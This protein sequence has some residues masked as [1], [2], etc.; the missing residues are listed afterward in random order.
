MVRVLQA[1]E[2]V[3]EVKLD[4]LDKGRASQLG[5]RHGAR[6]VG[7]KQF[8]YKEFKLRMFQAHTFILGIPFQ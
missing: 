4:S 7:G 3:P 5:T 8:I 6:E 2:N 1:E